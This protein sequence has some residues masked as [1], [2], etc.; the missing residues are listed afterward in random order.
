MNKSHRGWINGMK[1]ENYLK[2]YPQKLREYERLKE[3]NDGVNTQTY[4][5]KKTEFINEVLKQSVD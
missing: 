3:E 1:F 2:M 4:Y 5:R